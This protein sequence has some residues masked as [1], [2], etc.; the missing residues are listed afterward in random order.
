[1]PK[2]A[3][4]SL[5]GSLFVILLMNLGKQAVSL[6]SMKPFICICLFWFLQNSKFLVTPFLNG[7]VLN[8]FESFF[9][10]SLCHVVMC[11][12]YEETEAS[13]LPYNNEH[14]CISHCKPHHK[15][16]LGKWGLT[17]MFGLQ[18]FPRVAA[19]QQIPNW[20]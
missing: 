12:I 9:V 17:A 13:A 5:F 16:G 18:Q 2:L 19:E 6:A 7:R 1:M 14:S 8:F 4:R 15:W 20:R 10:V 3:K 11:N